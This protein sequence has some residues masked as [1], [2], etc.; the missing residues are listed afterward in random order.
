[1][2]PKQK[3]PGLYDPRFEHDNCGIGAVA[4]IK[5]IKTHKTV[6]QALHIVEHLEHRAGKDAEGKTGDGVGIM[7]QISHRFFKKAAAQAGITLGGEREYGVGMFFFPQDELARKQAMKMFEII[8]KKEGLTFLGWR[9]VPTT[10][11]VLGKKAVDVMPYIVQGFVAKPANVKKGLDFD[12]KL[13]VVRRVFEQSNEDTYVVSLSSRTIVYK[14]MFLVSELRLFFADLQDKDYESAIAIVHSRFSTNTNPSWMRAHPYRFIVHNGEINTI[15]GNVDKMLAREENMESEYFKYDMHKVLPI[16][17]QEGSDSA[18]LDNALEFMVMSGMDLPLAVMVTIPAPWEHDKYMDSEIKDF[19]RYYATMMEPWDGPASILFTDGD[20]VGAI[21]D[22]NGLRPSRYY[23]TDD[24]YMILS[25]EVGAIDIDQT[26]IVKKDRLRPGKMLLVDTVEGKMISDEELKLRYAEK[27]PYGEWLD[28]NLVELED[29]KV[30]NQA[31]PVLAKEQRLRL[32]KTYGYTYEQYR[33]M[34]LPMALNGAEAVSAMGVD[35]PLAVLS[36]K[37]QP[38]FNYFK[39]LFA[40][41]TNPPIDSIREEIVTSTTVY[42]GEEGNILEETPENC[43]ILRVEN[44]ILTETDLLKIKNMKKPGFKVEVIPIT[45]YKN[46]SLEKAIDRLFLEVDRAHKDGANIIILSDRDIDENHVPIPSL[47][48]VSALQQYLVRT[49]KRTSVALILESGEPREVHHFATLLGYGACAINPYLAHESIRYLIETGMLNKD[50][51][52]AVKDYDLAVLH[53]IVKIASKMGISTIQSYQG[54]QIFESIGISKEVVDK[55]FTD[56]VSRVGGVTLKDIENDMDVLHSAAFDPLGLDVD[57]TLDSV[58]S[59]KSRSGQEEHLYNPLTIHLLQEATRKG[60]YSIFKQYTDT[61]DNE[62]KTYHLRNLMD[63]NYPEDGGIPI[64]QV[65]SVDSIVRRFKTG[66]MSYGSISQEAHETLAIAMNRIHGKSNTGEGGESLERLVPG[67]ADNNRCSA[68]KQVA[69]GRFGVTSRYLVSAQEIQ[70]KMAQGAKPGEGGQL[71]GKKVYPWIAKTRHSTTGVSLIS[72]PPH[73]DI[74]SIEDLAQLIYDLKNSNT[75][76]RISVKLVSEAGVGTVAAGVA[77]AGAQV[78]LISSYDGGTGAAP[79]NSIYNAGLPW[80]LGVAEAHQSLIMNGLRDRVVLET[81]GKLMT[82]RDV[83]IACMLGAEEFGF[84]TAPLVTMGCVMMRVCNLD[85]CPMGIA[86]QNPELRKRFKGKPEYVVN[87]MKFI[88]EE[89][90]EY[91][92]KLGVRTVDELVGRTDLLK[93]KDDIEYSRAKEVDLS[94]ILDNP[95]EGVK[96]AGYNAKEVYDFK[97]DETVDES[98]L[99]KKLKSALNNGQKKS[100]QLDVSNVN[101]TLGTIF[102]SEI[103]RK[104]PDG[105]PEDTFTISCNGSGGQSFGAFIPK[106]L[107]LELTGDSNDY[108][109][110]GLSGGKLIVYPPQGVQFKAEDNIIIGNVA[111]YGAT[112]GKAFI[113]GIAGER[114]CVRNSGATA[115]VEGTGDHGCEYMT[116]GCV[117]V[118]GPTGK[119]FAAGMSGGIAYVLDEDRSFYKRLNKELVS[120]EDVSN[121]YDVL[122]LKGLIQEHVAYTNSEKGKRILD[123]FSEYLPKFK[124]IVPHDYRRMMNAIVQMEEKGLNSE[125]AQIEAF[126][127]NI[128]G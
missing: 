109:G 107:T 54:S 2:D 115:V 124:K 21:L 9:D 78:I 108:F 63:F 122:E 33:T 74:Y 77:K 121:K 81:D 37:H 127:A 40:Q 69:S 18:M 1:M 80:E 15:R 49:K 42:V 101:R 79:R 64:E 71:P 13:Y 100:I 56:T 82:G 94:R 118:L 8:V 12:R 32:Q 6:D 28:S 51:Y 3:L 98:I 97:L 91:M 116:G 95:Y 52:A 60:D 117:V 7:L 126:Y 46:T 120:F 85:T 16:I 110:K 57:L 11:D 102:G 92:A 24:G 48:A 27:N 55:Y 36:K 76:A 65:E 104:Y 106:G 4:N 96:L 5:G 67:P 59:H 90:R 47:L 73:H 88:A 105:L 25:S 30:P 53:G 50:Y 66:A 68:I 44:P 26:K 14:G 84:A 20:V 19:Y 35:S 119:N 86:T 34:I 22:R 23:I 87:F 75:R 70:I 111:L 41:V 93:R 43:K 128:R 58:G 114:F 113:N 10:P 72:P 45:Y 61:L 38:L 17:N 99:L 29:L 123:H 83:A 103:T 125:Q 39:Q 112:S 89:L 31:A 62:G